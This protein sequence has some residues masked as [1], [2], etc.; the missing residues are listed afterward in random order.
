[1]K[2]PIQI[3]LVGAGGCVATAAILFV[4][5]IFTE[6]SLLKSIGAWFAIAAFAIAALPMLSVLVM[7]LIE[8]LR[9]K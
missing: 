8:K 5:G 2:H 4:T 6:S 1:M 3:I 9:R 7:L